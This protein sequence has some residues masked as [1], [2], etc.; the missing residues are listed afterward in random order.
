M[1]ISQK[2]FLVFVGSLLLI[3]GCVAGCSDSSS[4]APVKTAVM[5][6]NLLPIN[7]ATG[8]FATYSTAG[9][10]DESLRAFFQPFGS[11]GRSCATCHQFNQGQSISAAATQALFN[12]N[13]KDPL[14]DALNGANCPTAAAGDGNA[15]SL[16]LKNGLIRASIGVAP[17]AQFTITAIHDPYGCAISTSASGQKMISIYRRPLPTSGLPYI[18]D[19]LWDARETPSGLG[20]S[21]TF[22]ANLSAA[23]VQTNLDA[24]ALFEGGTA[25][26]APTSAQVTDILTYEQGL[27]TAQATDTAAGSLTANG[28]TGGPSN[29][30]AVMFYPGINDPFGGDPTGKKFTPLAFDLYN[31]WAG[32]TN[33]QQA[34]I[35]RGQ[36]IFNT[37]GMTITNVRGVNDNPALGSPVVTHFSC[38]VCHDTPDVGSHSLSLPLDIGTGRIA[39]N[40]S[41]ASIIAG[42]AQ[43]SAP[44]LPIYQITG[45]KD[46]SGN[47][48]VYTTTDPGK[49]L[50]TGLCADINRLK[51]PSLRGLA[52]RAP[53]FHSGAASTLPQVVSFYNARF[54]MNLTAA[55]QTDLVN[56][57]SAL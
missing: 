51:V 5:V 36:T 43:L 42:L 28:A 22:N 56:F 41:D 46:T 17:N 18:S 23:L 30:A 2:P 21:S 24:I 16:L 27:F 20:T 55:Q 19:V 53:Y 7:D 45:C 26:T 37:A 44:D 40:E 48:V 9:T 29:F 3:A 35:N 10:T 12:N 52:A 13:A 8:T 14:F 57:L 34:S 32:S 15:R 25:S 38:T 49:G 4:T 33:A 50:S 31:A 11:N 39:A 47:S 6:P 54:Q 1:Q